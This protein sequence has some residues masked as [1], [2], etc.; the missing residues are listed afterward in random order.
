MRGV[1]ATIFAVEGNKHYRQWVCICNPRY[2]AYK[3]HAPYCHLWP[4]KLCIIF[5]YYL[6]I[7]WFSKEKR[8][9]TQNCDV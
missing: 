9:W 6:K 4:A 7:M 8:R 5:P 3:S 2:P 1:L